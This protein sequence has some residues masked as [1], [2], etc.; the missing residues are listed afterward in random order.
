MNL[1]WFIAWLQMRL[2]SIWDA[3]WTFFSVLVLIF[4]LQGRSLGTGLPEWFFPLRRLKYVF[5]SEINLAGWRRTF[6]LSKEKIECELLSHILRPAMKKKQPNYI[7]KQ[8]RFSVTY[9]LFLPVA[10][11]L[12][13]WGPRCLLWFV[14]CSVIYRFRWLHWCK[15]SEAP[16]PP[17]E[18]LRMDRPTSLS[19]PDRW[20]LCASSLSWPIFTSTEQKHIRGALKSCGYP[21]WTFV[22]TS[23]RSSADRE[24]ETGKL[25]DIIIPYV[26]GK[27]PSHK[28]MA[29]RRRANSSDWDSAVHLHLKE[30]NHFFEENNVNFLA[31][32]DRWFER[33]I[34]E[35]IFVKLERLSLNR[36]CVLKHH[37]SVI[38]NA[39]LSSLPRQLNIHSNLGSP[40][41][42]RTFPH[43][44]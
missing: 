23:E 35:S 16:V 19:S 25:N 36:G 34:K 18:E 11:F 43:R 29:Q 37:L 27:Q 6:L 30:E 20:L 26:V 4:T 17:M 15:K 41:P 24:E 31:R 44:V 32:E 21:N 7:W 40:S 8:D 33:G 28:R 2:H 5:Y 12:C 3:V 42:V 1:Q 10:A 39:V 13:D 22:K 38:Y 14:V 9:K